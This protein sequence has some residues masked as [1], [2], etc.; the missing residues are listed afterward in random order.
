VQKREIAPAKINLTLEITGKRPDGYHELQSLVVFADFGDVVDFTPGGDLRISTCGPFAYKIEGENLIS[1]AAGIFAAGHNEYD[2]GGHFRLQKNLPI[3]AGLGGGSAD[4]AAALRLL[5]MT[6]NSEISPD[7]A[8]RIGADVSVCLLAR[9]AMMYGTGNIV[10][11]VHSLPKQHLLL[12]NPGVKVATSAIFAMLAARPLSDEV[13][14]G[15]FS[16]DLLDYM[17]Q[18]NNDLTPQAIEAEP[19]IGEVLAALQKQPGCLIARMSGSGAT[20]FGLFESP[21]TAKLAACELA[22]SH[23]QWWV[24]KA[25]TTEP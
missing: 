15:E 20:C 2:G 16:G 1:K 4:A 22:R 14:Y 6:Y 10:R 24:K 9:P 17:R 7:I 8:A 19:L 3:A 12:V 13:I 21:V 23:P 11:P 5:A 25:R 18:H